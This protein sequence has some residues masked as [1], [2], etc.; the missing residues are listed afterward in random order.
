M[1]RL[2][3]VLGESGLRWLVLPWRRAFDFQGR[4]TRSELIGFHFSFLVLFALSMIVTE[5]FGGPLRSHAD[6]GD[7]PL[8]ALVFLLGLVPGVSVQMRRMHDV[9]RNGWLLL[10]YGLGPFGV[11]FVW[12]FLLGSPQP[13]PN[14]WGDDPREHRLAMDV[15]TMPEFFPGRD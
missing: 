2:G 3:Q 6:P 11:L 8:A 4:S 12:L 9:G 5:R 13:G 7:A 10:L 15:A 14:R 1:R